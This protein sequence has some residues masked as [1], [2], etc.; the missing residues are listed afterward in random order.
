MSCAPAS[1]ARASSGR[2]S[3]SGPRASPLKLHRSPS[4]LS[5][6]KAPDCS[7]QRRGT[8]SRGGGRGARPC[9]RVTR[10]RAA[11]EA[12]ANEMPA[13]TRKTRILERS[14]SPGRRAITPSEHLQ[15][16]LDWVDRDL[17]KGRGG[18]ELPPCGGAEGAGSN[19]VPTRQSRQLKRALWVN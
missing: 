7:V 18:R 13:T 19:S 17:L 3:P 1:G 2:R 9:S 8:C 6:E 14:P 16:A 15:P 4:G 12:S 11:G 10:A 5:I